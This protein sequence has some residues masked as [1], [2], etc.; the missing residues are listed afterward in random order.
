[1]ATVVESLLTKSSELAQR[2]GNFSRDEQ[3][4][5][6]DFLAAL[7]AVFIPRYLRHIRILL[8]TLILGGAVSVMLTSL[9]LVQPQRLISSVVSLWIVVVVAVTVMAHSSLERLAV[10][11]RMTHASPRSFIPV[12]AGRLVVWGLVPLLS[13][14]ATKYPEFGLWVTKFV[15]SMAKGL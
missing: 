6:D 4:A 15:E 3:T 1:V 14:V 12:W 2:R 8:P 7:V 11:R 10:I 5:I 13:V 9:Y